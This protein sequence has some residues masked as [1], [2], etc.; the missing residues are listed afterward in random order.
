MLRTSRELRAVMEATYPFDANGEFLPLDGRMTM[1]ASNA[2]F[3]LPI[4]CRGFTMASAVDNGSP[5]IIQ[6]SYTAADQTGSIPS[7]I[8]PTRQAFFIASAL[9]FPWH[10][11]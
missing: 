3:D 10:A 2:N 11:G 5:Q 9:L 6:I 8:T 1:L 4:Q 7:T